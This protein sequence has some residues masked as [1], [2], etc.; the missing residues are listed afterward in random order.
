MDEAEQQRQRLVSDLEEQMKQTRQALLASL[1]Q[2]CFD[3]ESLCSIMTM[4]R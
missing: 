2:R 3:R 1:E 4:F